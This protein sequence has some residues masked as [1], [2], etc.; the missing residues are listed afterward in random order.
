[1]FD[2]RDQVLSSALQRGSTECAICL[3]PLERHG[4]KG[5][6][7]LSCTHVYHVDCIGA[8][9]AFEL[10]KSNRPSCPCCRAK[11]VWKTL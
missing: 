7:W 6:A 4:S 9:E 10:S 5:V 11:Y 3:G 2:C 8:F 1:M